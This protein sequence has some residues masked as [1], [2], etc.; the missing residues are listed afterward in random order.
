MD[1]RFLFAYILYLLVCMSRD[2]RTGIDS[3]HYTD[4]YRK[5]A[6]DDGEITAEDVTVDTTS[7]PERLFF[8]Q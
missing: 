5:Y 2:I 1:T 3:T 6:D 7:N 4:F 8:K